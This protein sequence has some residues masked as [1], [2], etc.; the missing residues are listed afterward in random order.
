MADVSVV[1]D[2]DIGSGL[3]IVGGQL[4]A[5]GGGTPAPEYEYYSY[6]AE[7]SAGLGANNLEWSWGNG[8]TGVI[9]LPVGNGVEV[10]AMA[11]H[12]DVSPAVSSVV[13]ELLDIQNASTNDIIQT[14]T[15]VNNGDG[16]ANNSH[17]YVDFRSAPIP[18]A[19]GAV[20]A[21]GTGALTGAISSARC[22]VW[23]RQETGRNLL[24]SV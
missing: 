19:D 5:T 6:W 22:G 9:G 3:A 24:I 17:L 11:F 13:I 14:I 16:Q 18:C 1:H 15:V 21:F 2:T 8:D 20:L 4:V 7:E 23:T 12:A 10:I